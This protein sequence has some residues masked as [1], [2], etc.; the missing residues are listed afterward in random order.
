MPQQLVNSHLV[1]GRAGASTIS[2]TL[3]VGRPVILIPL[4]TAA[5]NHQ[6]MNALQMEDSHGWLVEEP[7]FSI[8][9]FSNF[10]AE[11]LLDTKTRREKVKRALKEQTLTANQTIAKVITDMLDGLKKK[12]H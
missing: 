8:S 12:K 10:L 6:K 2:E 7:S 4:P 11:V 1:I 3:T 9:K 5:D